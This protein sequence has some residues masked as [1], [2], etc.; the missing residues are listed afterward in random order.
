VCVNTKLLK[1][2]KY[3]G[4]KIVLKELSSKSRCLRIVTAV[5]EWWCPVFQVLLD[6]VFYGMTLLVLPIALRSP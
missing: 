2:A 1:S 6:N 4:V 5:T 3:S